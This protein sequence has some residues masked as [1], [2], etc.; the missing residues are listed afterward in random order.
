MTLAKK[1]SKLCKHVTAPVAMSKL[2]PLF[3]KILKDKEAEVRATAAGIMSEVGSDVK[4][5]E[6]LVAPVLDALAADPSQAVR[7]KVATSLIHLC[8]RFSKEPATKIVIPLLKQLAK[9]DSHDVRTAVISEIDKL[10]EYV[11]PSALSSVFPLLVEL[12]K[13]AKWRVRA[14]VID[15]S[16]ILAKH[17]GQKKFE[18]QL[19]AILLAALSD[20]VFAIRERACAQIGLVVKTFGGK[21]AAEKLF[22]A[23]FVIYDKNANYLYRMTCLLVAQHVA[24][25]CS[26]EIVERH[27]LNMVVSA[28]TDEVANVRV[29]ASKSFNAIIPRLDPKIV[30]AKITPLLAKLSKDADPDVSWFAQKTLRDHKSVV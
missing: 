16:S 21:W 23:A 19:Q 15:K 22:P 2:I 11:D 4:G 1:I 7:L 8:R 30:K 13:D 27:I 28:A 25:E 18:R 29:A 14:A 12:S 10:A 26:G 20:H 6:T 5:S 17:M 9:D 24:S 3:V